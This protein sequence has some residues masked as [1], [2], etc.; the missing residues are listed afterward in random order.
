MIQIAIQN[1]HEVIMCK[2]LKTHVR[3]D[4][5]EEFIYE[6]GG[7]IHLDWK[8]ALKQDQQVMEV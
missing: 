4:A 1:L 7:T 5:R 2:I 6:E 8:F 3:F